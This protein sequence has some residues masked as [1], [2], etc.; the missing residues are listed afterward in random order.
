MY[1]KTF[2]C[3]RYDVRVFLIT[4][5]DFF[6][7]IYQGYGIVQVW[8]EDSEETASKVSTQTI[9]VQSSEEARPDTVADQ[10]MLSRYQA[11]TSHAFAMIPGLIFQPSFIF[12]QRSPQQARYHFHKPS[13]AS[14]SAAVRSWQRC[15]TCFYIK[16][17]SLRQTFCPT[18]HLFSVY[19]SPSPSLQGSAVHLRLCLSYLST[20]IDEIYLTKSWPLCLQKGPEYPS[21]KHIVRNYSTSTM[22]TSWSLC[23][24]YWMALYVELELI[25]WAESF[26]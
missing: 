15:N 17:S 8:H 12:K 18:S 19:S 11:E 13:A 24:L 16:V 25:P 6:S 3:E 20:C 4:D 2:G 7:T 5:Y 9:Q 14:D 10:K 1:H 21:T 23:K 22:P 26:W